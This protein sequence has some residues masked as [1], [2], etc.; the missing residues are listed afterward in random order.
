MTFLEWCSG[1]W[2]FA[3][4]TLVLSF[5]M[6]NITISTAFS[7][8]EAIIKALRHKNAADDDEDEEAQP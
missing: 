3:L 7:G 6:L 8:L 2:L 1:H 4:A 5:M